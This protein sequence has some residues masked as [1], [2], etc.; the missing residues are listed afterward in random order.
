MIAVA[1]VCALPLNQAYA[2][3]APAGVA[4]TLTAKVASVGAL[5]RSPPA[6]CG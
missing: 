4:L 6:P 2:Q 5:S 1:L 3:A